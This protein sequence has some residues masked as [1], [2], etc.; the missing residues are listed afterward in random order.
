MPGFGLFAP[1]ML[2]FGHGGEAVENSSISSPPPFAFWLQFGHGGEAVENA[3]GRVRRIGQKHSFNSAT[4]VRPWKTPRMKR[5]KCPKVWLQFGH[6]GE[7][8]EN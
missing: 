8:V 2:Q 6:G 4:A 3:M 7:A 5:R 1:G